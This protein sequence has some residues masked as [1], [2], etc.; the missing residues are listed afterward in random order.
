MKIQKSKI[1]VRFKADFKKIAVVTR[2]KR[3]FLVSQVV[4]VYLT[5]FTFK[6]QSTTLKF[7]AEAIVLFRRILVC[8][9]YESNRGSWVPHNAP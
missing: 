3:A 2:M 4:L 1:C 9:S 7:I 8:E 5:Q 6:V